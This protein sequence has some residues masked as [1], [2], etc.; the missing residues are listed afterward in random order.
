MKRI[1]SFFVLASLFACT[2]HGPDLPASSG[3]G[4][5]SHGMIVLGDKLQD[6]YSVENVSKALASLYPT[7]AVSVDATHLYVRFLPSSREQYELLEELGVEMLDHP[8]DFSIVKEGDY[9][10]D[11]E[12]PEGEITWQYAVVPPDFDFPEGIRYEL[13]DRCHIAEQAL[14]TRSSDGID[15]AAVER[16]SFRLTGNESLLHPTKA[17]ESS[18]PEGRIS[19]VDDLKGE[20]PF[21]VAGVRVSCNVFV[22]FAH[23][24]TDENGNYRIEKAFNS[25]PRYRLVFKNRKG[26]GIGLNLILF[27]AS[28]STLGKHSPSGYSISVSKRSDRAL[29]RRCVVNNACWDYYN[30][31][32]CDAGSISPPPSNLRIWLFDFL[33]CS[34]SPM[35]QQGVLIDGSIVEDYLGKYYNLLKF[36]L[37][38]LTLGLKDS[39]DYA[40]IYSTAVHELAHASHYMQVGSAYWNI[41]EE[42]ILRS[43]ISSGFITYGVGTEKNHG[44]CEVAEMWAYYMQTRL[45][46]ERYPNFQLAFGT[47]FWFHPQIF[48]YL[49]SRG[50]TCYK[51]FNALVP[52]VH[53]KDALRSKLIRLYPDARSLIL[54]AFE[55]YK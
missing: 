47:S 54:L 31:C 48:N 22:K 18:Y 2:A 27:P 51:T 52:E 55:N 7:K 5:I 49:D 45:F 36:F 29:F 9:Y 25:D 37:P 15:W 11:P 38:D 14:A 13:L 10:H 4:E 24:Y 39:E 23:T 34:S 19:I 33:N 43:F 28:V 6:P 26:F 21:G 46:R 35:L 44:Y 53:D 17:D 16:E 20:S 12:I 32:S 3:E 50:L 41:L 8:V 42:F 1:A 30:A 40:S